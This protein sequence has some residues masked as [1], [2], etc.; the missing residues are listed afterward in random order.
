MKAIARTQYGG[1]EVLHVSEEEMPR[2]TSNQVLVKI[3]AVSVNPADWHRMRA[4][5]YFI[6]LAEGGLF[7]PYAK[8]K[9]IGAD[10]AGVVEAVGADVSAYKVG[11][12]VLGDA[13]FG[14]FAEYNAVELDMLTHKPDNVSFEEAA[15]LGI[16]GLTALQGV[17]DHGKLKA[18]ERVLIN[19]ASGG[20]GHFCV[21]V[22]KRLGAHVT[23]VCSG[24]NVEMLKSIGANAVIDY[25]KEDIHSCNEKFDLVMDINGN[26]NYADYKRMGKRGVMVG[27]VGVNHMM[28]VMLRKAIGSFDL[29]TFTA[30]TKA[31][32]LQWLAENVAEG[33][34][35][36][37][38]EKIYEFEKLPEAV[39][40]L[41][42]MHARGKVVARV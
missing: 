28:G 7:K 35:K 31:K 2:Y 4:T 42:T 12:E 3:R 23:G 1:P 8:Y 24:K 30:K 16:A 39:A 26:L 20:V 41:E 32:D 36:P 25:T 11:D 27:F 5:P 33:H 15:S 29:T 10:F 22:A 21:Q 18:G 37:V 34:I 17:R 14:S 6:R 19:G 40:H 9:I 13:S 38:I